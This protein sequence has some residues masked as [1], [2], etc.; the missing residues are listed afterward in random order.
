MSYCDG[1]DNYCYE[2]SKAFEGGIFSSASV[3]LAEAF[4]RI[5]IPSEQ[6]PA[7]CVGHTK[8][9]EMKETA[10][11]AWGSPS[12]EVKLEVG[13]IWENETGVRKITAIGENKVLYVFLKAY[14]KDDEADVGYEWACSYADFVQHRAVKRLP[15]WPEKKK[16]SKA[17]V[18][19][20]GK[21]LSGYREYIST[22]YYETKE[23]AKKELGLDFI[24]FAE[25]S[26]EEFLE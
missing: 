13:Q 9:K 4:C 16:V 3:C 14:N 25:W 10:T 11:P 2:Y 26:R 12:S 15:C 22:R 17:L 1:C 20:K 18:I 6:K 19:Y 23:E 24:R 8:G 5:V 7:F 21:Y